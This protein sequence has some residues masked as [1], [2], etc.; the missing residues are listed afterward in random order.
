MPFD[1]RPAPF[2][3]LD[4]LIPLV[5]ILVNT[6]SLGMKGAPSLDLDLSRLHKKAWVSD[7][8]YTPLE[9]PLIHKARAQNLHAVDGLN[10]L[11]YQAIPGFTAWFQPATTPEITL[12]LRRYVLEA[13]L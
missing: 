2:D 3:R 6:T 7:L 11:L 12:A 4:A 10:M 8:V 9:T 13:A 5:G 1:I